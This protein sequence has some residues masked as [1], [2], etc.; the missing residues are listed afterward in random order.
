MRGLRRTEH[1]MRIEMMPLIDVIFLLLTFFIFALVVMEPAVKMVTMETQSLESM[2]SGTPGPAVTL[3]IDE[4][5]K[6]FIDREPIAFDGV[7]DRLKAAVQEDPETTIFIATATRGTTDRLPVFLALYDQLA[8]AGLNITFVSHNDD[9][10]AAIPV[11]AGNV[12][13]P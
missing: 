4:Q 6:L 11:P 7:L 5:G 12:P 2:G 10:S 1:D 9:E 8:F 3:S 13:V